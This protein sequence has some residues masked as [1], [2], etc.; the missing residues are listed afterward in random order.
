MS[1]STPTRGQ[2]QHLWLLSV[3][4][5]EQFL[6]HALAHTAR[7]FSDGRVGGLWLVRP[8]PLPKDWCM[9]SSAQRARTE[10]QRHRKLGNFPTV[11][12][13]FQDPSG[14]CV[15]QHNSSQAL[16]PS[17][18][19]AYDWCPLTFKGDQIPVR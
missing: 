3:P 13:V 7:R 12:E 10:I 14:W 2:F 15:H 18:L 6:H 19:G 1:T 16:R 9:M 17:D 8:K 5:P 4:T 11:I